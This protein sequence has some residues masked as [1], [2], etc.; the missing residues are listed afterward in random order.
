MLLIP[1]GNV[2]A[3]TELTYEYGVRT[4]NNRPAQT[5]STAAATD[6]DED[7]PKSKGTAM[8]KYVV[9]SSTFTF[10]MYSP[11]R[12]WKGSPYDR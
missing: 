7:T 3:D 9:T 1:V 4:E 5:S 10:Y 6:G 11:N 8:I 12:S 2:T